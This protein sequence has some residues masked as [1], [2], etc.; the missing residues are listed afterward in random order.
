MTPVIGITSQQRDVATSYGT[1]PA[2]TVT[3]TYPE[4]VI[5]AG[6]IPLVL[7]ILDPRAVPDALARLDGVLMTG[8]GDVVAGKRRSA[9]N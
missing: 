2:T 3:L 5:R 1:Q 9:R 8:G 7:P 6:G 4:A